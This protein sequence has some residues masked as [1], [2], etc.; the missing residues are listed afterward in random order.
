MND[1]PERPA[2]QRLRDSL[3]G[4]TARLEV[5]PL[6]VD[7]ACHQYVEDGFDVTPQLREFLE[8]Y[9]ELTIAWPWRQ[10]EEELT[11]EADS[12]LDAPLRNVRNYA[13]RI[14]QPVLPIGAVFSSREYLLLA[15][16]GD[17][18]FA[19]DAGI[20]RVANGFENAV[21]ALVTGD[22]DKTFF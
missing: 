3:A 15:E 18:L 22:W 20:Q 4:T 6:D 9:G 7:D 2:V 16:N 21:R 12:A 17:I 13:N 1:T 8:T 5:G 14:G 19:G 10:W 11:T